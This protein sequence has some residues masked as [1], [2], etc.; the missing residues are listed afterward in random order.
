MRHGT[1][2]AVRVVRI[3]TRLNIGGPS[4]QAMTLSSR[5][6]ARGFETLLVHGHLGEGEGDMRYLLDGSAEIRAL[7][8]LRRPIAPAH[9]AVAFAQLLD[10]L[11]DIRPDIV[12]THM[13]KAGSL[14]RS[15]AAVYNATAG[16]GR[17]A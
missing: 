14:G 2:A 11:R 4:I 5:L 6:A 12:H 10:L 8:A 16:R 17:R 1:V 9:D 13:A 15:A 3:I 7:P